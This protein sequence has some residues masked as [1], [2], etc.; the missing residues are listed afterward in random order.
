MND[1]I[2]NLELKIKNS[3]LI[4]FLKS[5]FLK[6]YLLVFAS[7]IFIEYCNLDNYLIF[8]GKIIAVK[9]ITTSHIPSKGNRKVKINHDYPVFEYYRK[10]DTLKT[11]DQSLVLYSNFYVGD[12]IKIIESKKDKFEI[13][14]LNV[15]Y[16]WIGFEKLII[17]LLF[18]GII[19]GIYYLIKTNLE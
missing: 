19:Y 3:L 12:K 5:R 11:Q 10:K 1:S 18:A 2:K 13:R 8:E 17:I 4:E 16:Y 7:F 14:I 9:N 15:F 6:I